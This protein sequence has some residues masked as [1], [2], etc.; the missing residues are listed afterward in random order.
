[1]RMMTFT[2]L[3]TASERSFAVGDGSHDRLVHKR[4]VKA[5]SAPHSAVPP[6]TRTSMRGE[7]VDVLFVDEV[8]T[9]WPTSTSYPTLG[10]ARAAE[11]G[12]QP[13][14]PKTQG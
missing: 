7:G 8:T 1:M 5:C 3:C 13:T 14:K 11:E 6:S 10:V 2:A 9:L 12:A 4:S